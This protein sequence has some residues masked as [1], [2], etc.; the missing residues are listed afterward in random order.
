M[1][2]DF[3]NYNKEDNSLR[4]YTAGPLFTPDQLDTCEKVEKMTDKLGFD[5]FSPRLAVGGKF[6]K[7]AEP[8]ERERQAKMI[9]DANILHMRDCDIMIANLDDKDTGTTFELAWAYAVGKPVIAYSKFG[10]GANIMLSQAVDVYCPT[11]G[12][13]E[14]VLHNY[15]KVLDEDKLSTGADKGMLKV[16]LH[17]SLVFSEEK[18]GI[19][20]TRYSDE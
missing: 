5:V 4:I 20:L 18:L 11:L 13:L 2:Q 19:K 7:N 12:V 6:D 16:A 1:T 17:K 9:F 8:A 15:K 14:V 10:H 3:S